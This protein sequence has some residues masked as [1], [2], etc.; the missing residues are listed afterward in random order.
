[1]RLLLALAAA[2]LLTA[3]P[4]VAADP[5]GE[6]R[7]LYNLG[8]YEA[9]ERA[10]REAARQPATA[11]GARLVLGRIH[12]ERYRRSADAA[13]LS[14]GREALRAIDAR[15]LDQRDRLELTIGLGE[16]LYLENRYGAA[17]D[18][19]QSALDRSATLGPVAYERLLDWWAT[20]LDRLA[21]SRPREAREALYRRVLDR[22]EKEIAADP[23]S[24]PAAYWLAAA[25]RGS[26]DI[27]RA[28]QSAASGWVRAPLA[29]DRGA[30]LRADI[31]RLVLQ[32]LIPERAVRLQ[33]RDP[34]QAI[35]G[36]LAEW[37]AFKTSW[38]R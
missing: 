24:T 1:M 22:M 31:D 38:S 16:A 5:L 17:A 36:M 25:A 3:A 37:E 6:A 18:L 7:R 35:A 33:L 14:A 2:G 21:Q 4:A 13:D 28:W 12:L 27:E 23:G 29:R 9:A 8:D 26:G 19:F 32:A 20:A 34:K 11:E 30:A 15:A 10:A